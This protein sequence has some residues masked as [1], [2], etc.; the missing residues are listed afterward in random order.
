LSLTTNELAEQYKNEK[1]QIQQTSFAL[2][3]SNAELSRMAFQDSLTGLYNVR[4]MHEYLDRELKRVSR[5]N[6]IFSFLMFDI[7]DF[8]SINDTYGHQA[9]DKMLQEIATTALQ[10]IRNT[11]LLARYGGEEFAVILPETTLELALEIGERLRKNI[12]A[13]R[14]DWKNNQLSVTASIG[15]SYYSAEEE[16]LSKNQIIANADAG[17]Y[18]SKARGKN[19]ISLSK[20]QTHLPATMGNQHT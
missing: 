19:C 11:D 7:D 20:E 16:S 18:R 17:L 9:G 13:L 3:N 10:T 5:Y 1:E 14:V 12:E 6:G 4:Y 8:K 2:S 15:I